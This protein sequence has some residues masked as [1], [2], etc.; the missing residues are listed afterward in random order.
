MTTPWD[1]EREAI[2]AALSDPWRVI[3]VLGLDRGAR[4]EGAGFKTSCPWCGGGKNTP[5]LSV[6]VRDGKVLAHCFSCSS[7]G[8]VFSLVAAVEGITLPAGM[9]QAR[10]RAAALANLASTLPA[11]RVS[12]PE[13]APKEVARTD[14]A[15]FHRG[16]AGL[17]AR[18]PL[19]GSVSVG[20]AFRGVLP[21]AQEDGWGELPA[22]SHTTG[23]GRANDDEEDFTVDDPALGDLMTSIDAGA[24]RGFVPWLWSPRGDVARPTHRLLIPWRAPDGRIWNVQRRWAPRYGDEAAPDGVPKYVEPVGPMASVAGPHAFGIE[25]LTREAPDAEVWICEGA[26]DV[27]AL[28]ALNRRG[29]LRR[30]RQPRPL[31]ALGLPGVSAW[32][33]IRGSLVTRLTG[34][35]VR[36][37]L[38]GD[39]AGAGAVRA[40]AHDC[41]SSGAASVTDKPPPREVKDW[42]ELTARCWKEDRW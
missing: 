30:D 34:R 14:A 41:R 4:R 26:M 17:L 20:L 42:A 1:A 36:L 38:D 31:V 7:G 35:V 29:Y 13:K 3:C 6:R 10:T 19:V 8:D 18:C 25:R 9:G 27:L 21:E 39:R 32:R 11:A 5:P 16:A 2:R 15:S 22:T 40:L 28:R 37:A 33:R 12:L 24:L 23:I